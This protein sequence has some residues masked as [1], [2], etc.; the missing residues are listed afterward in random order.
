MVKDESGMNCG[1]LAW[2]TG[3]MMLSLTKKGNIDKR[4]DLGERVRS[5]NVLISG[6]Q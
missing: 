5:D 6:S 1:F 3:G 4:S 2:V